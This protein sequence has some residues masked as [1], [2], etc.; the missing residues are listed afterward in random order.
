MAV[1][2]AAHKTSYNERD[3][4]V[5]PVSDLARSVVKA[6]GFWGNKDSHSTS[7]RQLPYAI[8]SYNA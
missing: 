5:L 1:L 4:Q 8:S 6:G 7:G 3:A 2:S